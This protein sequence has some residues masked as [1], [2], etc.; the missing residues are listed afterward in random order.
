MSSYG[1]VTFDA[2]VDGWAE[3]ATSAVSV[4]GF[5][6]GNNV[7][8]SLGGQREVNRTVTC[9]FPTRGEYVNFALLR[10][11]VATLVI[12]GWD[13]VSAVLK[14]A[15]PDPPLMDGSIKARAQF[16]LT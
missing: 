10:G 1:G 12:D 3:P 7:A 14:E 13:S 5:P 16:V 8:V 4:R 15:S 11:A 9:L 6:G 2:L